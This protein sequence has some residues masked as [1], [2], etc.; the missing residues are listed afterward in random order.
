MRTS[1]NLVP[2]TLEYAY[3]VVTLLLL[4]QGPVYRLWLESSENL[5]T[6]PAPTMSHAYFATFV[7]AQIPAIFLVG[8]ALDTTFLRRTSNVLLITLLVWLGATVSWAT[9]ARHSLPEFVALVC[10]TTFGLYLA[11][12]FPPRTMWWIILTATGTGLGWSLFALV[13]G[14]PG[15]SDPTDDY[16]IGIYF[17]RNSL[18]PVAAIVLVSAIA[19]ILTAER[20]GRQFVI[21]V[22]A[23]LSLAAL[24]ILTLWRSESRTSPLA[25]GVAL[26]ATTLWLVLRM[27]VKRSS[28]FLRNWSPSLIA[29]LITAF[30]VFL[31]LRTIGGLSGAPGETVTFNSRGPLWSL[32]W[33]GFQMRPW[34][35]WGWLSAWH[36]P[37]FFRQGVWWAAWDTT[38][39]H[40]GYFDLLLG[41]GVPAAA[42]FAAF[43]ATAARD[44]DNGSWNE[45]AMRLALAVF[46]LAAATQESF[47]IGSHFLWALLV[48]VMYGTDRRD[49]SSVDEEHSSERAPRTT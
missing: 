26:G 27:L 38:W 19:V 46:V 31:A 45:S 41:G 21:S 4:T 40:S 20:H 29:L 16:W 32:S 24:A 8:R 15:A 39:A 11:M 17:N 10:T 9:L 30:V 48:A 49:Q 22:I 47:F 1:P 42:L 12:R 33:S 3:A 28:G 5:A 44:L 2:R 25:L 43:V 23:G 37:E 6:S 36:T 34:H 14:W 7:A 35:G 13:R 18:A